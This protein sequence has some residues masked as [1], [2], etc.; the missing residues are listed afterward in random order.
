MHNAAAIHKK[1]KVKKKDI[2]PTSVNYIQIF[3]C[4]S[5]CN[6]LA[7]KKCGDYIKPCH[8]TVDNIREF[9]YKCIYVTCF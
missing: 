2:Q 9:M 6:V 5:R 7:H 1:R 4:S 3:A 8:K